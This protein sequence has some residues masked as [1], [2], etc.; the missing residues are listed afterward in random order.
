ME[1]SIEKIPSATLRR[2]LA[3]GT[4]VLV[5]LAV[6]AFYVFAFYWIQ[7]AE[8]RAIA[9][10][11]TARDAR[12]KSQRLDSA[13]HILEMRRKDIANLGS[14]LVTSD[15]IANFIARIE[16]LGARSGVTL[17]ISQVQ[18]S[19]GM[20]AL[21]L[22]TDGSFANTY[23]FLKLL[24]HLPQNIIF[25]NISFDSALGNAEKTNHWHA[26]YSIQLTSFFSS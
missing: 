4:S 26:N 18:A 10:E 8:N 19:D 11:Q 16:D 22:S 20:L 1:F 21:S 12:I 6:I 3:T 7:S 9:V 23:Y 13:R 15:S 25:G 2:V 5:A 14:F 17:T 24:E